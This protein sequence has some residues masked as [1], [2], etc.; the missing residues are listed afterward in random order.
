VAPVLKQSWT[1][2]WERIRVAVG[3]LM[4]LYSILFVICLNPIFLAAVL[5]DRN[6]QKRMK[7]ILDVRGSTER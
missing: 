1:D 4:V 6:S 5:L 3:A 7:E 2:R